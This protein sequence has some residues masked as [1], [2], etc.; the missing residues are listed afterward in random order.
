MAALN[1]DRFVAGAFTQAG[2]APGFNR[3]AKWNGTAW[4]QLGSGLNS[5]VYALAA[6]GTRVYVGGAFTTA[7]GVTR[8]RIA[9]W[10]TLNSTWNSMGAGFPSGNVYAIA[11]ADDGTVYAGGDFPGIVA[12]WDEIN[13]TWN[14]LPNGPSGGAIVQVRALVARGT[15]LYVGGRFTQVGSPPVANIRGLA[16]WINGSTW[17]GFPTPPWNPSDGTPPGVV[18]AIAWNGSSQMYVTGA[19]QNT[20][21]S[22]MH[23]IFVLENGAWSTTKPSPG[24][25]VEQ[26]SSEYG[27][28]LA[29]NRFDGRVYVGGYFD[30]AGGLGSTNVAVWNDFQPYIISDIGTLSGGA[31]SFGLGINSGGT[32]V[33]YSQ[34]NVTGYGLREH[35]YY[36]LGDYYIRRSK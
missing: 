20:T 13:N 32:G 30:T 6:K 1:D 21:P 18:R 22:P 23:H 36:Y 12:K 17:W 11:V 4:S 27:R 15:T 2:G 10:N 25:W 31:Y 7:G 19:L 3:I 24:L 33:G 5:S 28:A 9:Y 16:K 34:V 8:N 35:A 14:P 29:A 26:C